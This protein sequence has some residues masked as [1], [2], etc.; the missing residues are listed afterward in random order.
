MVKSDKN[1]STEHDFY[2]NEGIKSPTT[3]NYSDDMRASQT[4]PIVKETT[5]PKTKQ[6]EN[7][8]RKTYLELFNRGQNL[9][10]KH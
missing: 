5:S 1:N 6:S 7:N 8:D 9:L 2:D 10:E 3:G 4:P